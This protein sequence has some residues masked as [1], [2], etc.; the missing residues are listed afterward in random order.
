MGTYEELKAAIQQVIR[1]NGN[2]EITGALLQNALLSIVNVVGANATFAGIATPNT[3]PG[4][5][6]QNVFYLATEAGT[7]VNFGGIVINK[8]EAVILSNKTG[9]WVKTVS[10]FATQQ[11]LTELES[12]ISFEWTEFGQY[13]R[14]VDGV[15]GSKVVSTTDLRF[16]CVDAIK[17]KKGEIFYLTTTGGSTARAYAFTNGQRTIVE[18]AEASV[19]LENKKLVAPVD[20]YLFVNY[21]NSGNL[22]YSLIYDLEEERKFR[23]KLENELYSIKNNFKLSELGYYW[24]LAD[25]V[26]SDA[27]VYSSALNY[28]C[29]DAIPVLKGDKF[30]L[31]TKGGASGRAYAFT[32]KDKNIIEVA[33]ESVL[34]ESFE[35]VAPADGYLFVNCAVGYDFFLEIN[36]S[37]LRESVI[38]NKSA[39]GFN[40]SFELT[41][42]AYYPLIYDTIAP[43]SPT[44][45]SSNVNQWG[46]LRFFVFKGD[47]VTIATKGGATGRAYAVTDKDL[48]ILTLADASL[49]T[50]TNPVE[51]LIEQDGYI[52]VNCTPANDSSFFVTRKKKESIQK[53]INNIK[54]ELS[55]QIPVVVPCMYNP[56]INLQKED[57]KILDIGNSYTGDSQTYIPNILS[58]FGINGGFS[59]FSAIRG[60]ASFKSWYDCYNDNDDYSGYSIG[61]KAGDAISG[62]SGQAGSYEGALFRNA[63][64]AVKWDVILIH[65][66]SSYA[67]EFTQWN[68]HGKGG[69]LKEFIQILRKTNPQASIGFLLVHSYRSTYVSN[70][71]GSSLKRWENI[72][73][74]TQQFKA[75]YGVDFIIPYG[76]AVQ[77]L[78]ASSLNDANEFSTDGTHMATGL[79]DYVASCCYYQSLFAPRFG[80]SI[81]GNTFRDT[82][83]DESEAGV[84]KIDDANA[85][86]AQKAAML[87]TYNMWEIMNPDDYEL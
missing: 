47:V 61:L 31:T 63:L 1:T 65:Q 73:K 4:T 57:L 17:V 39:I 34:L 16:K 60:G 24:F 35:L 38:D 72:A 30:K 82:S 14:L 9:N 49:D 50:T 58:A 77:N 56:A 6:D 11:Q 21:Y 87:A 76:T 54:E 32:D 83:L 26:V 70:A 42:G 15:V 52:Y 36:V 78:R 48:N 28:Q 37:A 64:S 22:S 68:E 3:N 51:L 43:A 12:H 25:S 55:N 18:V 67:N 27:P 29:V 66:V 69:Y 74:A 40:E 2:K 71:E 84:K 13:W 53:Q 7:Y 33:S 8:G 80:K 79:G 5:A 59:L 20:G 62:I 10:G 86:V 85:L 44:P 81:L 23:L 41:K 75:H 45:F 19:R 46:C